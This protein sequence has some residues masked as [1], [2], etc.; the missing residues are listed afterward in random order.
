M[1][2]SAI[3]RSQMT[4]MWVVFLASWKHRAE[5]GD[6]IGKDTAIDTK[7]VAVQTT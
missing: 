7:S 3:M 5:T 1:A 2:Y 6:H 4:K